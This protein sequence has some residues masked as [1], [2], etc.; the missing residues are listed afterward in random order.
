M[1]DSSCAN[2]EKQR[3]F[4]EKQKPY[5]RL[6]TRIREI[7]GSLYKLHDSLILLLVEIENLKEK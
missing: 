7:E 3:R 4:R 2:A 1:S 5:M 6:A